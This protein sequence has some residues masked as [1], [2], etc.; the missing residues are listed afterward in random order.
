MA[1]GVS[2]AKEG[3]RHAEAM[4]WRG[5]IPHWGA[6]REGLARVIDRIDSGRIVPIPTGG[7]GG[8]SARASR[9]VV[10]VEVGVIEIRRPNSGTSTLKTPEQKDRSFRFP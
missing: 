10:L 6:S 4:H 9:G 3:G 8:G 7:G 2:V 5:C 1:A